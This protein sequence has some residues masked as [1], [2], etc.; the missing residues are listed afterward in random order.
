MNGLKEIAK[1]V[2]GAEAFHAF[3]HAYFWLSGTTLHVFDWF[4]ETPTV[5]LWGAIVNGSFSLLLGVY[6]WGSQGRR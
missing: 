5:H 1:F 2:A 6:A 4:N 3:T